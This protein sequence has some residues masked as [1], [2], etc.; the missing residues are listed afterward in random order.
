MAGDVRRVTREGYPQCR[1]RFED[2]PFH[3][4]AA[5]IPADSAEEVTFQA[6]YR[7]KEQVSAAGGRTLRR[8]MGGIRGVCGFR[9]ENLHHMRKGQSSAL[10]GRLLA[11]QP[12]GSAHA[13]SGV[14]P[15]RIGKQLAP[16]LQPTATAPALS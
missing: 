16:D 6:A 9:S 12:G 2:G 5:L 10:D 8:D 14:L 4:C 7:S 13:A 15:S 3:R 11:R 1:E